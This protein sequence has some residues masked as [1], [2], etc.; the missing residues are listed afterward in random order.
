[1]W[2]LDRGC[3]VSPEPP[4]STSCCP[5]PEQ[6]VHAF[7]K[8]SLITLRSHTLTQI[9]HNWA[10]S[11]LRWA[12]LHSPSSGFAKGDLERSKPGLCWITTLR[13]F[14]AGPKTSLCINLIYWNM[15]IQRENVTKTRRV[16][17]CSKPSGL[18]VKVQIWV[19]ASERNYRRCLQWLNHGPW[20]WTL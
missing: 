19:G 10:S 12:V 13:L 18:T 5:V 15:W 9:T 7:S 16:L 14:L 6:V 11:I 17:H 20:I 2:R 3:S 1:M 8:P 4:S